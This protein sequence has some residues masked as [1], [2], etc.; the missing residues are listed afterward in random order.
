MWKIKRG[1]FTKLLISQL[2]SVIECKLS[3]EDV[4]ECGRGT[5]QAKSVERRDAVWLHVTMWYY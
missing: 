5:H 3:N 4:G 2:I 1:A